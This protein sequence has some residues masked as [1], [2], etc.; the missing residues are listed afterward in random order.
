M[1]SLTSTYLGLPLRNPLVVS[2]SPLDDRAVGGILQRGGRF[3]AP[4]GFPPSAIQPSKR[5]SSRSCARR[6]SRG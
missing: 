4:G 2:D 3:S 5:R 6:V 1:P